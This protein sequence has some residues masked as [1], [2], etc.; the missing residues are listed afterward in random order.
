MDDAQYARFKIRI[1]REIFDA[2]RDMP[3]EAQIDA[4]IE[5]LALTAMQEPPK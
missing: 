1:A 4:L 2:V 3:R 5:W